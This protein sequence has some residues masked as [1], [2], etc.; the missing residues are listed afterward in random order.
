M[1]HADFSEADELTCATNKHSPESRWSVFHRLR[2][3]MDGAILQVRNV[4]GFMNLE[5]GLLG[6]QGRGNGSSI[7]RKLSLV[8]LDRNQQKEEHEDEEPAQD[9]KCRE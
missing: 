6:G 3:A 9:L 4:P 2:T 7:L 8:S 1:G 5:L